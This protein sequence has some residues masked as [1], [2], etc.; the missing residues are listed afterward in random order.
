[1]AGLAERFAI[2]EV[3]LADNF[4]LKDNEAV[5]HTVG[6]LNRRRVPIRHLGAGD[7]LSAAGVDVDVLHPPAGWRGRTANEN[8]VVLLVRHGEGS[9]LLTGALQVAGLAA[10][11]QQ[12]RRPVD[13]LQAPHHA[14]ARIDVAGLLRWCKPRL[15][16]SSQA[17][18]RTSSKSPYE[19]GPW[20]FWTTYERGAVTVR[21]EAAGLAAR[22]YRS[23]QIELAAR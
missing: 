13:V 15:V 2:G 18:P 1:M 23:G 16:V 14:S 9:I 3:L 11:L 10:M 21:S 4:E 20:L 8:S 17:A 7:R 6:A 12:P 5:K 22:G 19:G